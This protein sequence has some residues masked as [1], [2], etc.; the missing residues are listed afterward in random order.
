MKALFPP[1]CSAHSP[2]ERG[3]E[4]L[5][6]EMLKPLGGTAVL[7]RLKAICA[8]S[9]VPD[10]IRGRFAILVSSLEHI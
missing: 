8:S 4:R 1:D 3:D 9:H 5:P 6:S 10:Q 7:D 2:I